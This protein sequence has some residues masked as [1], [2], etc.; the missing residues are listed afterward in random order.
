MHSGPFLT[1]AVIECVKQEVPGVFEYLNFRRKKAVEFQ[2]THFKK[3]RSNIR[4]DRKHEHEKG[5][6]RPI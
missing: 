5:T 4:K 3:I 6:L 2:G 1:N